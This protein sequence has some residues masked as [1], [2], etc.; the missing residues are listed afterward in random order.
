MTKHILFPLICILCTINYN[1]NATVCQWSGPAAGNW[2]DPAN[3]SCGQVPGAAD[4]VKLVGNSVVLNEIASIRALIL[5]QNCTIG[6]AGTLNVSEKMD[7]GNGT[8]HAFFPKVVSQGVVTATMATLNFNALAFIV[9][10]T[11]NFTQCVFWMNDGGTF[12]IEKTGVATFAGATNFYSFKPYYGFVV[13]GTLTKS[14]ASN[15]DFE[16]LYSFK[17]ATINIQTGFLVNYYAEPSFNCKIDSSTINIASGANLRIERI[18][19][20]SN[21]T[22]NGPGKIWIGIGQCLFKHPNTILADVEQT[23][24]IC[25]V[26]NG[27]DTLANYAL[28]GGSMNSVSQIKGNLDW[29]KGSASNVFV[30]GFTKIYDTDAAANNQKMLIGALT[31]LG[32]GEYTGNDQMSG[33]IEIPANAVFTLNA[34][35]SANFKADLRIFGTLRKMNPDAVTVGFVVNSGRIEGL[36]KIDGTV[37]QQG[38]IAPGIG[39]GTGILSFAGPNLL[40][41]AQQKLEIQVVNTGGSVAADLL[42]LTGSCTLKGDLIVSESG[43]IPAG[44]YVVVQSSNTLNGAFSQVDLPPNWTLI[45]NPSNITL[46]KSLSP[47]TALFSLQ[48]SSMCAPGSVQFFDASTGDS[49]QY[50]WTFPGGDPATSADQN[51]VVTYTDAGSFNAALT[52]TNALSSSTLSQEI[53]FYSSTNVVYPDTICAG[54]STYFNGQY[55]TQPG[56][57]PIVLQTVFGCDSLI[58][59]QLSNQTLTFSVSQTAN[60]LIAN[61]PNATLQWLDCSD[62]SPVS[63]AV[64]AVFT[65]DSSGNYAVLVSQ[66]NCSKISDC[67]PV[68]VVSTTNPIAQ[69]SGYHVF[70]NPAADFIQLVRTDEFSELDQ[71]TVLI[72][73]LLGVQKARFSQLQWLQQTAK[74][75]L[76]ALNPGSYFLVIEKNSV[77]YRGIPVQVER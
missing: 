64:E 4:T 70:P 11:A 9:A 22:I 34:N 53:K 60:S 8:N 25:S 61:A 18:L 47:P 19:N 27:V 52:V 13:R 41:Q 42:N 75:D 10:G 45:Q 58:T 7:L 44:D 37:I 16:A 38:T 57:Y 50:Q 62:F 23:G 46:R 2:S 6:G 33:T 3:W 67:Y 74:L 20:I 51:P 49:L 28:L 1:T 15:M 76:S 66:G 71:E 55:Y 39:A 14:G 43:N 48:Q 5:T 72:F 32:G 36:G 63:G 24:G 30:Q 54:D 40:M 35:P 77:R 68:I 26:T 69:K 73:D 21:S 12:E 29:N 17:N 56:V 59:L 65:P 31:V